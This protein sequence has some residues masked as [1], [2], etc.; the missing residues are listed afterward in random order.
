[1]TRLKYIFA[2]TIFYC[3]LLFTSPLF[4]A[5]VLQIR[6]ASLL[7]IG[8]QNRT[9]TVELSCIDFSLEDKDDARILLKSLLPRGQRVNLKPKGSK[10]GILIASVSK[11]GHPKDLTEQLIEAGFG[12]TTC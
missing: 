1:M 6:S 8:D 5:E 9:Y 7:Q 4:A 10:D 3:F 12:E 2:L 11:I